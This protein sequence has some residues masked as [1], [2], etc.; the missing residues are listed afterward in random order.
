MRSVYDV[1]VVGGGHAGR[2]RRGGGA[3]RRA[4]LLVTPDLSRI[5]Q[6]SC[7]PAIGGVAKGT[8]VREVDALGGVMGRATDALAHPVPHAQPFEGSGRLGAARAVRPRALPARGAAVL[9]ELPAL[10][11]FQE[12][13]DELMVEGGGRARRAHRERARLPRPGGRGDHRHLPARAHPRGRPGRGGRAGGRGTLG[14][15]RR[16]ARG[17]RPRGRPLQDRHPAPRRRPYGDF[18][19]VERQDGDAE[20]YR[21]SAYKVGAD[22]RPAPVLDHVGGRAGLKEV[23]AATSSGARSTGA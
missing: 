8:S 23:V 4:T 21:F 7:N 16:A 3:R 18:S 14:R 1:V 2:G 19:R 20:A 13:V 17:A 6:M 9:E 22:S 11:M 10:E 15:A 12:M 5:G